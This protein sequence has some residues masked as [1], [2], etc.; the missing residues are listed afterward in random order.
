MEN[1]T[2][3]ERI[4]KKGCHLN[5]I[6]FGIQIETIYSR[7]LVNELI[8]KHRNNDCVCVVTAND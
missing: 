1:S 5:V 8:V 4:W 2:L 7:H 3:N 6:R